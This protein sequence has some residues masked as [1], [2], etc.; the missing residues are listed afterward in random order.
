[1]PARM[2]AAGKAAGIDFTG[3]TD[4]YPN[5]LAAHALLKFAAETSPEKQ[6]ALQEV[7]FRHY[8]TDGLYPSEENLAAAAEEAGLDAPAARSFASSE[9]NQRAVAD[10]ARGI[11][12][13]GVTGV[14][15]FFV[16]GEPAFSGA[17]PPSAFVRLI[18]DAAGAN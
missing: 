12:R 6:N 16:N 1:M 14:P 7:L 10:E 9:K 2:K 15:F 11:S 8:F 17:Q 4:R 5:S 13:A 18:E 3:K